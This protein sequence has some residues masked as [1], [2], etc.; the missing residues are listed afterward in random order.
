MMWAAARGDGQRAAVSVNQVQSFGPVIERWRRRKSK[1][2]RRLKLTPKRDCE[3]AQSESGVRRHR[4]QCHCVPR[5]QALI[6]RSSVFASPSWQAGWLP[7]AGSLPALLS[8][9]Y[10]FLSCFNQSRAHTHLLDISSQD[11]DKHR[12]TSLC[13]AQPLLPYPNNPFQ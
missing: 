6:R 7:N 13:I 3:P 11:L 8:L 1:V 2:S 9:C 10:S 5:K 12:E 4:C